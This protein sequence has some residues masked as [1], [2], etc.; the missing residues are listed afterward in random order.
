MHPVKK[1]RLWMVVHSLALEFSL[2]HISTMFCCPKGPGLLVV[3]E[4]GSS[5]G[6]PFSP[7]PAAF[8]LSSGSF[9]SFG[10]TLPG[11]GANTSPDNL[12]G[13]VSAAPHSLP[14]LSFWVWLELGAQRWG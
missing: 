6:L 11:L 13:L 2:K 3:L 7:L 10:P 5:Q 4:F 1:D 14:S 12:V 9:V 8:C